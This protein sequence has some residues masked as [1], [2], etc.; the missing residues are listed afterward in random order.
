MVGRRAKGFQLWARAAVAAVVL[1]AALLGSL[2]QGP[3]PRDPEGTLD[4]VRGGVLRV[5]VSES[6]PWTRVFDDGSVS[7]VEAVLVRRLA[8]RLDARVRW[9]PGSESDLM[10]ALEAG[11]LDLVV[12]GLGSASPWQQQVALTT[13][14]TTVRTVI[15]VPPR[16]VGSPVSGLEVAVR[17]DSVEEALLRGKDAVPVP[18]SGPVPPPGRP[19]VAGEWSLGALGLR[20]SGVELSRSDHAVAVRMGENSWLTAV[21]SHLLDVPDEEVQ[22][23]LLAE[24]AA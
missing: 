13:P 22:R 3:W 4:R 16:L 6:P 1:L 15:G 5:G 7:G 23:L 12:G 11:A 19:A 21:E 24:G 10:A 17:P 14:Y 9:R 2:V 20:D 8:E 18:Y